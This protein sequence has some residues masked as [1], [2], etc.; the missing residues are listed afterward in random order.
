MLSRRTDLAVEAADL[1]KAGAAAPEGV[2]LREETREGCP[3]T[4]V[5]VLPGRGEAALGKPAGTYVTVDLSG[6]A[7]RE[8][9]AFPRSC[10]AVA[11]ELR[12]LLG[13]LPPRA[14]VLVV[15]LGNRAITP[16]A[17]GPKDRKS[18]V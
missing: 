16:D 15:G 18:V 5:K 6:L 12:G 7:R 11:A 3:V 17:I 2:R 10:R 4:R 13:D 14:P 9:G 8:E 1:G